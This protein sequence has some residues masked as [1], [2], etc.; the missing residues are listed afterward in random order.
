MEK[1]QEKEFDEMI[2]SANPAACKK[3]CFIK[4]YELGTHSDYGCKYC[5]LKTLTPEKFEK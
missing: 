4:L 2:K 3:H 1:M 5:G